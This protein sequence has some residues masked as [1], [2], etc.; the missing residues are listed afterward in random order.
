MKFASQ[1][2]DYIQSLPEEKQRIILE[3]LDIP[4]LTDVMVGKAIMVNGTSMVFAIMA[5]VSG[6]AHH[7]N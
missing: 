7:F 4:E 2:N 1:V 5:E 6:S 3:E